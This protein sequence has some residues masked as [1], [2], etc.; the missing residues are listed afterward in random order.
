VGK[1]GY[2]Y[3]LGSQGEQRGRYLISAQGK[4][5]GENIW[6]AKDASGQLFIQGI[7]TKAVAT[8]DGEIAHAIYPWKNEG[9]AKARTKLAA[10]TYHAAWDWVI[11]AGAYEDDFAEVRG[12]L[13]SA[14]NDLMRW[15]L[16][17]AA[18]GAFA[19]TA[20]GILFARRISSP[21]LRIIA[22]LRQG[23]DQI[24]AAA[25]QVT[26]ASQSLA[27]GSS[28]QAASLEESSSS[29]EELSAMTK[30]NADCAQ[31]AKQAASQARTSADTGTE[32]MRAM[33]IAMQAIT[34]SSADISKILKTID[35][36]SFQTNILALNA[37]VEAARA[38]AAGAGFAVVADEVRALAQRSALAAKETAVKIEDSVTKSRQGAQISA[39]VAASF[40]TIQQQVLQLDQLVGEIA[41][42][43]GEQSQGLGQITIA[44]SQMDQVTQSNAASAEETAAA[45]QDLNAQAGVLSEAIHGL[46][47]IAGT[48]SDLLS[49]LKTEPRNVI[50]SADRRPDAPA[51]KTAV[52]A[53]PAAA[54][55]RHL[56]RPADDQ[57]ASVET[58]GKFFKN[59]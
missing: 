15:V 1:T 56:A 21:I 26:S 52:P 37:A 12:Q 34:T 14:Q 51:G 42:A 57:D 2:V 46:Q 29:L 9:E 59:V 4:R 16:I 24:T 31:Y 54:T 22:D 23:S 55:A 6:E 18:V 28:E 13:E 5:D 33:Q 41:T 36:I 11:V 35:E 43:S 7:I 58:D 48:N 20:L 50:Y 32:H 19:A 30:R 8:H 40:T 45:S 10:M 39:E 25:A 44:I 38:G 47:E 53:R 49:P 27:E 3:V 17:V